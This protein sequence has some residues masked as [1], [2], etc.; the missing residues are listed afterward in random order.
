MNFRSRDYA[1][2]LQRDISTLQ[3]MLRFIRGEQ[4]ES[5]VRQ[6]V[7]ADLTAI[8]EREIARLQHAF[9]ALSANGA[10]A[11]ESVKQIKSPGAQARAKVRWAVERLQHRVRSLEGAKKHDLEKFL[12]HVKTK[13]KE[14]TSYT[15]RT[16]MKRNA[17][18]WQELL[19][20]IEKKEASLSAPT[21][22]VHEE[23]PGRRFRTAEE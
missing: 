21:A 13:R 8:V 9:D 6:R 10:G 2:D 22:P 12:E 3:N 16:E 1:A 19:A 17:G 7:V 4:L 11:L 5:Q 20:E 23:K 14:I 18:R 15:N